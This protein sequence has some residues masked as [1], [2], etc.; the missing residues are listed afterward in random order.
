MTL[1]DLCEPLFEYVCRLNRTARKGGE[2][3]EPAVR[4]E[5]LRILADLKAKSQAESKLHEQFLKVELPL[6]FFVDSMISES[7]LKFAGNWNKNRMAYD[8]KELAG[9]EKFFDLLDESLQDASADASERLRIYYTAMGL[10]FTGWYSGQLDYIQR[11][12]K[13]IAARISVNTNPEAKAK[14]VPEAYEKVDTRN[15]IEPPGAKLAGTVISLVGLTILLLTMNVLIFRQHVRETGTALRTI[16]TTEKLLNNEPID[17]KAAAA[18][19]DPSKETEEEEEDL[20]PPPSR[21]N[22]GGSGS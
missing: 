3:Q 1:S 8:R 18:V 14:I 5:V 9:D 16:V 13:E 6:I 19:E 10:G 20:P 21:R 11:K 7:R 12:M 15:L 4:S 17:E 22:T 2:A